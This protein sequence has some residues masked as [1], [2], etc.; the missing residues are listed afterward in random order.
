MDRE[1]FFTLCRSEGLLPDEASFQEKDETLYICC[2]GP[3]GARLAVCGSGAQDF[4]GEK[5]GKI[6]FCPLSERNLTALGEIFPWV[7]P[8]STAGHELTIGFGDRLGLVTEAHIASLAGTRIF[9]V[10]AQQS[11]R[12]LSLTGRSFSG[13]L[14]EV[15]WQVFRCG[16][17]GGYAADGDHLKTVEEVRQ[18]IACGATMITLDCSEHLDNR[19]DRLGT[20]EIKALCAERFEKTQ[21]ARWLR[22]YVGRSFAVG[23]GQISFS[24]EEL[25]S[26]IARYGKALDF[27]ESVWRDIIRSAPRPSSPS[28]SAT[29]HCRPEIHWRVPEGDRLYWQ[30]GAAGP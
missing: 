17:R 11:K 22:T 16:Y 23:E 7:L 8:V 14:A 3:T 1:I 9:P 18:A 10:L 29:F 20:A 12:E 30:S 19:V 5:T 2:D 6:I 27:M 28:S 24:E 25:Y 21:M 15:G 26:I 13:M 4:S